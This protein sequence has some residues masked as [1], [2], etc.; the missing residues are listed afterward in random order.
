MTPPIYKKSSII[1]NNKNRTQ[2]EPNELNSR[3]SA[4]KQNSLP[5]FSR[6]LTSK[7]HFLLTIH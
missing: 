2:K 5:N 4:R 1:K 3:T 7:L 6:I